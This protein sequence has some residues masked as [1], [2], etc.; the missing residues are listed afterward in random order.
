MP[1]LATTTATGAS[2][3]EYPIT[4]YTSD[5]DINDQILGVYL[6]SKRDNDSET[7]LFVGDSDNIAP[8]LAKHDKQACFDENGYNAI[9]IYRMT[10]AKKRAAATEDLIKALQPSCN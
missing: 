8:T 10:D 7:V 9:G 5:S 2:G 3:T 1:K 4:V 6:V